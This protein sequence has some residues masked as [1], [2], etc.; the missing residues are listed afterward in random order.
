MLKASTIGLTPAA[1]RLSTSRRRRHRAR[2]AAGSGDVAAFHIVHHHAVGVESPAE[3]A[4]AAFH[5]LD[6]RLRD[7]VTIA[8]E[9]QRD[10][11]VVENANEVFAPNFQMLSS[12]KACLLSD[13]AFLGVDGNLN[14]P[15]AFV[16]YFGHE[17]HLRQDSGAHDLI[18][19]LAQ[20]LG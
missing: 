12:P 19:P 11:F 13:P 10:D 18:A 8:V 2:Q 20:A 4:D 1:R 14:V 3:G 17:P 16:N 7:I 15:P 5:S 9:V 6:P